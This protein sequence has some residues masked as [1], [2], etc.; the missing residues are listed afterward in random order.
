MS[1]IE[2]LKLY[3]QLIRLDRPIGIL[4]LLWPTLWALWIAAKGIPDTTVLLVFI[5]G[6]ILMRS[7]GCA[8]NDFAD[9][10]FDPHVART[11]E[12]PLAAGKISVA[13][14]IV[15]FAVLA[16][17]AFALVLLLNELTIWLSVAG[18]ALAVSYPFMKRYHYL[19][20]VHLGAAF[21]WSVPMAFTAQANEITALTWLLFMATVLW[22]TAYD[23]LY[24]MAD[25]DEDLKIGVK[26]TA[27][28]FG[29]NDRLIVGILQALLLLD[30][31]L[32]GRQA[33]LGL[34]YTL[35]LAAGAGSF[36]Y[37]HVLIRQ[38]E[39]KQCMRA[40]LINNWFG[41]VVF[42]GIAVDYLARITS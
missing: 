24:A 12:R 35:G 39:P 40:F 10:E 41:L 17:A 11:R 21:G 8:I 30:L 23:T 6:V 4:L 3:A 19:P 1:V 20:Q 16:M 27:I 37:Q 2:R 5:A 42:T 22:A 34:Y 33:E 26:S 25:R 9:R 36:I 13:E 14:A 38:R 29:N 7:A 15:V 31:W 28:L 18:L 32:I